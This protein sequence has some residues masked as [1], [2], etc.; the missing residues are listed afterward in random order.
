MFKKKPLRI[1]TYLGYGTNSRLRATG[2]ALEDE[3]IRFDGNTRIFRTLYNIYKQFESDEIKKVPIELRLS[4]TQKFTTITDLE[5]YYHFD[6]NSISTDNL[7]N[8]EGWIPYTVSYKIENKK[9]IQ[10][11]IFKGSMLVPSA[12]A[13][14]G[15]ISDIDDT[16]LHTGVA[17]LFKWRVI[18][19][20]FFKN[21]D[22]RLPLEGTV[23]FYQKLR[24][25]KNSKTANPIFYV[26]NSP[27]NLYDYLNAFLKIHAFP[28]GPILLRD[29]R[30]FLDKTP[31]PKAP[32]KQTEIINLLELYPDM[33]FILIG[34]SGEKDADIYTSIAMKY[35]NRILAIYLR[36][37][38]HK[39]KERRIKR[40]IESFDI[41]PILLAHSS[42]EAEE[43]ARKQG[44]ID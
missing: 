19:N 42:L 16:I 41:A 7:V 18:A 32:H 9:I 24:K 29:F 2:R 8:E 15:V 13:S 35:P 22:R 31:K 40:I 34:D 36:S 12:N 14:Y 6:E 17:S 27:W 20:T 33:K 39:R 38:N 30:T 5:G 43:H 44:F 21:F 23:E 10:S 26:S 37:V 1:N 11:N 4:D 3:N 28:K 25:G